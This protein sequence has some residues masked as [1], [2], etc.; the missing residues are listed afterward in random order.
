MVRRPRYV[1]NTGILMSARDLMF[2]IVRYTLLSVLL[3]SMQHYV[4][5]CRMPDSFVTFLEATKAARVLWLVNYF[6]RY[7]LT[8]PS[9]RL[10]KVCN[11]DR[12]FCALTHATERCWVQHDSSGTGSLISKIFQCFLCICWPRACPMSAQVVVVLLTTNL[13]VA[14]D[15]LFTLSKPA[16]MSPFVAY[17][18]E[19]VATIFCKYCL[20]RISSLRLYMPRLYFVVIGRD[21]C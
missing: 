3:C 6:S 5:R 9:P 20:H 8:L 2:K 10:C 1:S 16:R 12:I 7:S 17:V 13:G 19:M 11:V 4:G 18:A 21:Q 14:V 15:Y